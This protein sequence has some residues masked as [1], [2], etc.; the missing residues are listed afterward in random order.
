[1]T[2]IRAWVRRGLAKDPPCVPIPAKIELVWIALRILRND[3]EVLS[4]NSPTDASVTSRDC[5]WGTLTGFSVLRIRIGSSFYKPGFTEP[6]DSQDRLMFTN[7]TDHI[8]QLEKFSGQT[9]ILGFFPPNQIHNTK[10]CP[11]VEVAK[12]LTSTAPNIP[13]ESSANIASKLAAAMKGIMETL[14][15]NPD[16]DWI[17]KEPPWDQRRVWGVDVQKS[18]GLKTSWIVSTSVD[19]D[20]ALLTTDLTIG[21]SLWMYSLVCGDNALDPVCKNVD[22]PAYWSD[23]LNPGQP[24]LFAQIIGNSRSTMEEIRRWIRCNKVHLGFKYPERQRP[25]LIFGLY[26]SASFR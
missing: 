19:G 6:P 7:A 20:Q 24:C 11:E 23:K 25:W 13:L 2:A 15:S 18:L 8:R 26:Y 10:Q 21:L 22:R 3:W 14:H 4:S 1:M 17:N 16:V 9:F 5:E 12:M